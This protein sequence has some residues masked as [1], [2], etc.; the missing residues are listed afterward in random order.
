[1]STSDTMAALGLPSESSG[2]CTTVEAYLCE[3]LNAKK[4]LRPST[5]ASYASHIKLY[6]VPYLGHLELGVLRAEHIDQMFTKLAVEAE[7]KGRPISPGTLRRI[8]ATLTSALNTAVRRSLIPGNPA[9]TVELPAERRTH[10]TVWTPEE[11]G[12]F[13]A[14]T[15]DDPLH[16]LYRLLG[17]RGLRRGEV[18]G[19]RWADI[20]LERHCLRIAQSRVR[21]GGHTVAG[22][23]KSAAGARVVAIDADTALRLDERRRATPGTGHQ[24]RIGSPIASD[25]VFTTPTGEPLD[26]TYVSRHFDRL[27]ARHGLP[28]IRLH[29][30]RHTSAS[31]GLEAG[32]TLLEVSRRLGHSSITVTADIYSHVSPTVARDSAERLADLVGVK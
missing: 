20:D 7:A 9:R 22:P 1:M 6:L 24:H 11:F 13:L 25:L 23:P 8:R 16:L 15:A 2:D 10:M 18:V 26:P 30:L 32:E 19:L 31:I 4:S 27:V 14:L 5:R 12:K 21:V 28:R 3:W 29:D 17:L